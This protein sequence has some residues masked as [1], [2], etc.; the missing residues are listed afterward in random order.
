MS[1]ETLTANAPFEYYVNGEWT[2]AETLSLSS[3]CG[4]TILPPQGNGD[5]HPAA[6][7]FAIGGR[8]LDQDG[9][10]AQAGQPRPVRQSEDGAAEHHLQHGVFG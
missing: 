2:E 9:L 7:K 8:G 4:Q 6:G 3:L 1:A 10:P 5:R